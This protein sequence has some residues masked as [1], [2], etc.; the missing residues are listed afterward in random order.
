[1]SIDD[2]IGKSTDMGSSVHPIF[3]KGLAPGTIREHRAM[4]DLLRGAGVKVL[5]VRDLLQRAVEVARAR[6]ELEQWIREAFPS[7]H[8]RIAPG[9][10]HDRCRRDPAEKRRG[11]LPEGCRRQS[12]SPVPSHHVDVL[13]ARLRDLHPE[14]RRH[15]KR[16]ELRAL[17]SRVPSPASCSATPRTSPSSR[18]CSTPRRRASSWTAAT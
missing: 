18:S 13:G 4:V 17:A 3:N 7:Q 15:R 5:E 11:V 6:G 8:E 16:P 2:S 9:D 14:G 1:M 10:R 12:R